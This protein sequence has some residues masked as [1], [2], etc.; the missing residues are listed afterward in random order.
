M[1]VTSEIR[2]EKPTAHT[3]PLAALLIL[4]LQSIRY[5]W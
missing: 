4:A 3:L 2:N 5:L 1:L